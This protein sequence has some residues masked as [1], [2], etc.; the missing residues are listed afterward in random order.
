MRERMKRREK[1]KRKKTRWG[2]AR[3]IEKEKR[4]RDPKKQ[5]K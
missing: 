3:G 5:S 4:R 1:W 2:G